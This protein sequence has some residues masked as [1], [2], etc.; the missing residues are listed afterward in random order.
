[1]LFILRGVGNYPPRGRQAVED[2][3]GHVLE[4]DNDAGTC[5]RNMVSIF[6]SFI[7]TC[8]QISCSHLYYVRPIDCGHPG[9]RSS[10]CWTMYYPSIRPTPFATISKVLVHLVAASSTDIA[11]Q[12]VHR[13]DAAYPAPFRAMEH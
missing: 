13:S 3:E 6:Y 7:S 5:F 10:E 8:P 12:R 1:M 2:L 4:A 9:T 11:A